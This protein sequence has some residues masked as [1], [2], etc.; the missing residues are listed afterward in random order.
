M[1]VFQKV[2]VAF[3]KLHHGVIDSRKAWLPKLFYFAVYAS[4]SA[5]FG[6]HLYF[7]ISEY[8]TKMFVDIT[9]FKELE[10]YA[11]DVAICFNRPYV[12]HKLDMQAN[13]FGYFPRRIEKCS[14][15]QRS[16]LPWF[17]DNMPFRFQRFDEYQNI[18]REEVK[19]VKDISDILVR[20]QS[21]GFS[22]GP[23]DFQVFPRYYRNRNL[24]IIFKA[25]SFF[26]KNPDLSKGNRPDSKN[27]FLSVFLRHNWLTE[28]S[29]KR[30]YRPIL[31]E[32]IQ[33]GLTVRFLNSEAPLLFSRSSKAFAKMV[34]HADIDPGKWSDVTFSLAVTNQSS[35]QCS[36]S[37][38]GFEL[39]DEVSNNTHKFPYFPALCRV[40]KMQKAVKQ[41]CGCYDVRLPL[42]S[43]VTNITFCQTIPGI[44]RKA[45]WFTFDCKNK[46]ITLLDARR[47]FVGQEAYRSETFKRI[48]CAKKSRG[49]VLSDTKC[50]VACHKSTK[51]ILEVSS[52]TLDQQAIEEE[53]YN[54]TE[55]IDIPD[56]QLSKYVVIRIFPSSWRIPVTKMEE[57]YPL[58]KLLSD[59]GGILGMW[60]GAS[61]IGLIDLLL[62][63][64]RKI[65]EKKGAKIVFDGDSELS[66]I[67]KPQS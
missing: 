25:K 60:L 26:R 33:M 50:P 67:A 29:Y 16:I 53:F 38:E 61:M 20:C 14:K 18:L 66:I 65:L 40:T 41:K 54:S 2:T 47:K 57:V 8:L 28:E 32:K 44:F 35:F 15:A 45:R 7:V 12:A 27:A 52:A 22:C 3:Q 63:F 42:E 55:T 5:F 64:R 1:T 4:L 39:L 62:S 10:H 51:E 43:T 23:E 6:V 31:Y 49:S 13:Y 30:K 36:S 46:T 59:L 48:N 11:P 21:R 56:D 24:C 58:S 37:T 34:K 19:S 17:N 9:S